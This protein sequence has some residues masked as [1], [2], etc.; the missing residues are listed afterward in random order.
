MRASNRSIWHGKST[1]FI[2]GFTL[3][4][5]L[6]VIAIIAILAAILFPVF[7]KARDKARQT[8]CSSNLKQIGMV[9]IMYT[10]DWDGY[11]PVCVNKSVS[12]W[13]VWVDTLAKSIDRDA[14]WSMSEASPDKS[15]WSGGAK[16]THSLFLCPSAPRVFTS[17]ESLYGVSMGYNSRLGTNFGAGWIS[18]GY[19]PR[20]LNKQNASLILITDG[21]S[22]QSHRSFEGTGTPPN[23]TTISIGRHND[24]ANLFF[25]DGHVKWHPVSEI[26]G[27]GSVYFVPSSR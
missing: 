27:W 1:V 21:A 7:A 20:D 23:N 2:K 26:K 18:A 24:G 4:E 11:L 8:V 25:A 3:I 16:S 17:A 12:P 13:V 10:E 14:A 19:V 9:A 5:L 15:G 22:S 6:V